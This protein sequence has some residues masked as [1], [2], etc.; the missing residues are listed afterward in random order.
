MHFADLAP[1]CQVDFGSRIRAIGWLSVVFPYQAGPV[2]AEF[3][4]ALRRQLANPWQPVT[5]CGPHACEFCPAGGPVFRAVR[6]LWVPGEGVIY[7]AP[8]MVLHYIEAHRYRPPDE[9]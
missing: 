6:N 8:E 7:V 3:V 9:F 2:P 5:A 1:I 4:E